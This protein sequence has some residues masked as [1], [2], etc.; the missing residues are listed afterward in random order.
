MRVSLTPNSTPPRPKKLSFSACLN[1]HASRDFVANSVEEKASGL[2]FKEALAL[3]R[4]ETDR[5]TSPARINP[6][7]DALLIN[8]VDRM[9]M[10]LL[11][12]TGSAIKRWVNFGDAAPESVQPKLA[13]YEI[14]KEVPLDIDPLLE[15]LQSVMKEF[16]QYE[17]HLGPEHVWSEESQAGFGL[18]FPTRAVMAVRG[19]RPFPT[20]IFG[21]KLVSALGLGATSVTLP[22][23]KEAAL[24]TWMGTQGDR[25]VEFHDLF[26]EAYR[27]H[28]G[29]LYGTILCAEN[30]L[31]EGLYTPDRQERDVTRKLSYLRSDSAPGGDNFGAWYHLMGAAL[32]TMVRPEWKANLI[33]KIENAGSY[34]LEGVDI[35]EDHI[36]KLGMQLGKGLKRVAEQGLRSNPVGQPYVNTREFGWDRRA[37]T[38]WTN[39]RTPAGIEKTT[40]GHE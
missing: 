34:I 15:T 40:T 27:L 10:D 14:G 37:V 7:S 4:P 33:L 3:A 13:N 1:Q 32:Y 18:S 29:D 2:S 38:S 17:P 19:Q 12:M 36:N 21:S 30:V 31:S 24:Q 25:S 23:G 5:A 20:P 6:A 28:E 11:R 39:H 9:P 8:L 16:P 26:R 35:Q 22:T